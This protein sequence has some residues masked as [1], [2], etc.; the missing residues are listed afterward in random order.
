MR[1]DYTRVPGHPQASARRETMADVRRTAEISVAIALS[2]V[3]GLVKIYHLPQGGSV[4]AG[5]MAPIF[6]VSLRWG[7]QAGFVAGLL[8]GFANFMIEPTFVHPAQFFLDYPFAFAALGLAG[9]T[10][11]RPALGVVMGG[12]GRFACHFLSGVVFFAAYAPK[13]ASPA[14]YSAVYNGSYMLPEIAV[15]VFLTTLVLRALPPA[16]SA[17]PAE[18]DAAPR[19]ATPESARRGVVRDIDDAR[20]R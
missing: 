1:V 11:R 19:A 20:R 14:A 6:F 5:S 15:S 17:A 4:T 13:G 8:T 9:L 3:L 12:A 2:V 16:R 7:W 10:P 18:D